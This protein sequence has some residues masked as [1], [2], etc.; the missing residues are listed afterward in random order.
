MV[1]QI[2]YFAAGLLA[3]I[4]RLIKMIKKYTLIVLLFIASL[5]PLQAG[6]IDAD[7]QQQQQTNNYRGRGTVTGVMNRIPRRFDTQSLINTG[8]GLLQETFYL[9]RRFGSKKTNTG[10][11]IETTNPDPVVLEPQAPAEPQNTNV[12]F[13][14][15]NTDRGTVVTNTSEQI[16]KEETILIPDKEELFIGNDPP[17]PLNPQI[18]KPILMLP[19]PQPGFIIRY[20]QERGVYE[21]VREI[22]IPQ[23]QQIFPIL[24]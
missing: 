7:Q 4:S 9:F 13:N 24:E 17:A 19:A 16:F 8:P 12:I 20:N 1:L 3:I 11:K 2:A 10:T 21:E 22:T 6:L 14:E 23:P 5:S 18:T 15:V